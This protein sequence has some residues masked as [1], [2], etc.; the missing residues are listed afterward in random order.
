MA[1]YEEKRLVYIPI[2]YMTML[3]ILRD[4]SVGTD[5]L[6]YKDDFLIINSVKSFNYI[7]HHFEVG[8]MCSI[9]LFKKISTNYMVF[10]SLWF[11]PCIVGTIKFFKDH[12]VNMAFGLFFYVVLSFYF[13][14]FNIIRQMA[15]ISLCMMFM[16][17]LYKKKYLYFAI[18]IILV[19][20]LF[21][22]SEIM[23]LFFIP[24]YWWVKRKKR[25]INKKV[26]YISIIVSFLFFYVGNTFLRSILSGLTM[27]VFNAENYANYI[28]KVNEDPGNGTSLL[29]SIIA[30]LVIAVKSPKRDIFQTYVV[31]G[32]IVIFNVFNTFS[33][34]A[35][36]VA[37]P[38]MFMGVVLLPKMIMDRRTNYR[39]AFTCLVLC[40]CLFLFNHRYN[41]YNSGAVNPYV[42]RKI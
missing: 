31:I 29:Y 40:L 22:K 11:L 41:K 15:V 5:F 37:Y 8:F 28:M 1:F 42:Y 7:R 18:A 10:I 23:Y 9:L 30:I 32:S 39:L 27:M 20:L 16:P 6:G 33:T 25:I 34:Y 19:S 4:E 13:L 3:A 35:V 26:L 2:V 24:L 12:K 17:L 21:H 14:S 36:R 38:F